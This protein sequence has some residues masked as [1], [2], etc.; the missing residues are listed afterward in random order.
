MTLVL[1]ELLK[2]RTVCS[3]VERGLTY[4]NIH[5][6]VNV[7]SLTELIV[8]PKY[9]RDSCVSATPDIQEHP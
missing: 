9:V 4:N 5:I 6:K 1:D 7:T 3:Q 2:A 8:Y